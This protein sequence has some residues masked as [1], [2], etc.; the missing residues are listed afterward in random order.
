MPKE[1][2]EKTTKSRSAASKETSSRSKKE[3]EPAKSRRAKKDPNAPKK[4]LSA[5][6]FFSQDWRERVKTENPDASF[7]ELGKI[8]GAKWKE[9]TEA[10]KKPYNDMAVKD[11][12]RYDKEKK[13]YDADAAPPPPKKSK[14]AAPK[15]E[16]DEEEE[17]DDDDDE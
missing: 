2:K 11:K 5:Y 15:S 14:K 7:G 6:M 4:N 1:P 12:G 8:L 17:E 10:E 9:I 3:K 16:E 13:D